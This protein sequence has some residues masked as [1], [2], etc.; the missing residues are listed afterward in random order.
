VTFMIRCKSCSV[1]MEQKIF[2]FRSCFIS[3]L[4]CPTVL[5]R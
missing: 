3:V 2:D 1:F 4:G 5:V